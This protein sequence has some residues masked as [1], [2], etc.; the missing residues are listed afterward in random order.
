MTTLKTK[1]FPVLKPVEQRHVTRVNETTAVIE[2]VDQIL[3][4]GI[5]VSSS[6]ERLGEQLISILFKCEGSYFVTELKQTIMPRRTAPVNGH[7]F[8]ATKVNPRE[9]VYIIWET[10][11]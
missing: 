10:A 4:H 3:E 7:V 11:P 5:V 6:A 1:E 8:F 9:E 2:S